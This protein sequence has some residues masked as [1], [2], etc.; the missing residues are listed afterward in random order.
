MGKTAEREDRRKAVQEEEAPAKQYQ[1]KE[2]PDVTLP[3]ENSTLFVRR[4]NPGSGLQ[5]CVCVY[6]CQ[7]LCLCLCTC[8]GSGHR[9]SCGGVIT[10]IAWSTLFI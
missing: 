5:V 4:A 7:C 9:S 10:K 3:V 8:S 1:W 2:I 6:V